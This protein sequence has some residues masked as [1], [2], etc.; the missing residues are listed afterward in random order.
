V[1]RDCVIASAAKQSSTR[2][3]ARM[4]GAEF[5]IDAAFLV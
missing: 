3:Q 4:K 1:Q 5:A 2:R